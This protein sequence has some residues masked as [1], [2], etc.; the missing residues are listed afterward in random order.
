MK[1]KNLADVIANTNFTLTL[2][3][4]STLTDATVSPTVTVKTYYGNGALVDQAVNIPFS[5]TPLS[6]ANL[7]TFSTFTLPPMITTTRSITASYFGHLLFSF[8]PESVG[9]VVNGSKIILTLPSGFSPATNLPGLPISCILNDV[10]FSCAYTVNPFVITVVDTNNSFT[11]GS[12]V[13]N[14]T[15]E[16]QNKNGIYYPSTQGRYL[17]Q[18]EILNKTTS[19]SLEKV[20]QEIEILPGDVGYFN[21]SWAVK[22]QGVYN[23]FTVEMKN[24][25]HTIPSYN[26]GANSGRIYIGF[27]T[28]ND[29]NGAVFLGNLGFTGITEGSVLPCYF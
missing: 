20:Q 25:P 24:G 11:T 27:P 7:V 14:I 2:Q 6:N 8:D 18:L 12:N 4:R 22:D 5:I 17:L 29:N 1:L 10:R 15:T 3:L 26:D 16:Y 23:I 28:I 19:E 13:L 9:A 21:V